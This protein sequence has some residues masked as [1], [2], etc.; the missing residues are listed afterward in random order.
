MISISGVTKEIISDDYLGMEAM[1]AGYLNLSSY[2]RVIK[3]FV[4]KKLGSRVDERSIVVALSRIAKNRDEQE[5]ELDI[6]IDHLAIQNDVCLVS[7]KKSSESLKLIRGAYTV[8]RLSSKHFF[9]KTQGVSQITLL[10]ERDIIEKT[11]K[12]LKVLKPLSEVERLVVVT[13][14]FSKSYID[15]PNVLYR[16]IRCLALKRVNIV[17]VVSTF[18]EISFVV[19]ESQAQMAVSQFSGRL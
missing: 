10:G 15:V 8:S 9:T 1:R 16:F 17:E 18:S 12:L 19:D 4:E 11:K 5:K 14:K 13:L 7:Y 2:A 3:P 6:K